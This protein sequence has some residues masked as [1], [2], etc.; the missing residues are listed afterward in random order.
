M[1]YYY[2]SNLINNK[3]FYFFLFIICTLLLELHKCTSLEFIKWIEITGENV[4]LFTFR[5]LAR[6][7]SSMMELKTGLILST[8]VCVGAEE[9]SAIVLV[10]HCFQQ[11]TPE[12]VT[13]V[14]LSYHKPWNRNRRWWTSSTRQKTSKKRTFIHWIFWHLSPFQIRSTLDPPLWWRRSTKQPWAVQSVPSV[15]GWAQLHQHH[16]PI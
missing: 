8:R 7:V 6:P 16:F 2:F 15:G 3:L 1:R 9:S 11:H 4:Q 12:L 13:I 14:A 10:L 5:H